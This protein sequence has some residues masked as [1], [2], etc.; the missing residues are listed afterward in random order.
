MAGSGSSRE[1][2][3]K[4]DR[5]RLRRLSWFRRGLVLASLALTAWACWV[6]IDTRGDLTKGAFVLASGAV[7]AW[8]VFV[9]VSV[10]YLRFPAKSRIQEARE[11]P[12][13]RKRYARWQAALT[14]D[15]RVLLARFFGRP[16]DVTRRITEIIEPTS[17]A[18]SILRIITAD[19]AFPGRFL[20]PVH[21]QKRG[22]LV[23]GLRVHTS[24]GKR[25]STLTQRDTMHVLAVLIDG[26][27]DSLVPQKGVPASLADHDRD[28]IRQSVRE[29][30]A[31]TEPTVAGRRVDEI[32]RPDGPLKT[33]LNG[34][35][36][37]S[38][39]LSA[40]LHRVGEFY[41]LIV[42]VDVPQPPDAT[43]SLPAAARTLHREPIR[44]EVK[45][46]EELERQPS[47]WALIN[48]LY[49]ALNVAPP[50]VTFPLRQADFAQSYHLQIVAPPSMYFYDL[51]VAPLYIE[52]PAPVQHSTGENRSGQEFRKGG[53]L[54]LRD[55]KNFTSFRAEISFK[56]GKPGSISLA[57]LWTSILSLLGLSSLIAQ[58]SSGVVAAVM[59]VLFLGVTTGSIWQGV[60]QLQSIFGGRLSTRLS[61][62]LNIFLCMSAVV[63]ASMDLARAEGEPRSL[64]VAAAWGVVLSA[65]FTNT[66]AMFF[67]WLVDS[68]TEQWLARREGK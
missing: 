35:P 50:R 52:D 1:A 16:S 24:E 20:M 21:E 48:V 27:I 58:D 39:L 31:S 37:L 38:R 57:F 61:S 18:L 17:D 14:T 29:I 4:E 68:L 40:I 32:N 42:M 8:I 30:L 33:R 22:Q 67:Y 23:D 5:G 28:I 44:I 62:L 55:A 25:L 10:R 6:L 66:A 64:E 34:N 9:G 26:L 56:E 63:L 49:T 19:I 65:S 45:R 47:R 51:D 7:A 54:Y 41:P 15:Q 59:P 3:E 53:H 36:K 60:V 46:T 11:I 12:F 2:Q 13:G 43:K